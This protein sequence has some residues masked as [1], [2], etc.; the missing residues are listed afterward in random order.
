MPGLGSAHVDPKDGLQIALFEDATSPY[1]HL[2]PNM[3]WQPAD[4]F[5]LTSRAKELAWKRDRLAR[6]SN[7]SSSLPQA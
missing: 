5:C 7:Q 3:L 6:C 4:M 1:Q 2:H